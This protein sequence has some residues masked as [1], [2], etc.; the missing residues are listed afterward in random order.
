M[1]PSSH[2]GCASNDAR[3]HTIPSKIGMNGMSQFRFEQFNRYMLPS[4]VASQL[5]RPEAF[6][7]MPLRSLSSAPEGLQ[8]EYPRALEGSSRSMTPLPSLART[9]ASARIFPPC[10]GGNPAVFL[11]PHLHQ[12]AI[13]LP[14]PY[15]SIHPPGSPHMISMPSAMSPQVAAFFRSF[16]PSKCPSSDPPLQS[17]HV[18]PPADNPRAAA[19]VAVSRKENV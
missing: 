4:P 16:K 19:T 2:H 6:Q 3:Y 12:S 5:P 14:S 7:A 1:P 13:P 17:D 10:P 15:S 18:P 9:S 11:P 8:F